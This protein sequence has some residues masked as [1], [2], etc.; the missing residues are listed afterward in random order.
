MYLNEKQTDEMCKALLGETVGTTENNYVEDEKFYGI[1][2]FDNPKEA[3][4]VM[5]SEYSKE[6]EG[7]GEG[8]IFILDDD[9]FERIII[10]RSIMLRCKHKLGKITEKELMRKLGIANDMISDYLLDFNFFLFSEKTNRYYTS[11]MEFRDDR[12]YRWS[13]RQWGIYYELYD[14]FSFDKLVAAAMIIFE[15]EL[16]DYLNEDGE[17]GMFY[18][19]EYLLNHRPNRGFGE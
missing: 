9:A 10:E 12:K 3:W 11:R 19:E 2:V 4:F 5:S 15:E 16:E 1:Q 7:L 8:R 14:T 18:I 17:D 13:E 6:C